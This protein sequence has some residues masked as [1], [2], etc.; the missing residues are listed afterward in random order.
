MELLQ[1]TRS[2]NA[3]E[4]GSAVPLDRLY[5]RIGGGIALEP[6]KCEHAPSP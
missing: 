6:F 2:N 4:D 5:Y 3:F 1:V